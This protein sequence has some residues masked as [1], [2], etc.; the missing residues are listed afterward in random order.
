MKQLLTWNK[1]EIM[2][3]ADETLEKSIMLR[4]LV[5][6]VGDVHQPLHSAELFDDDRF[7]KGDMGGN[8]FLIN[9]KEDIENLHKFWDS[10]ADNLPNSIYRVY[11]VSYY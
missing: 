1:W 10:G 11:S 2:H 3:Q 5:H 8:L 9:Y 4:Y 7:P 6:V